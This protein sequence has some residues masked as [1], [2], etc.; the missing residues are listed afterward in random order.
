[1][2]PKVRDKSPWRHHGNLNGLFDVYVIGRKELSE[3][4][5]FVFSDG[6]NRYIENP[7]YPQ[8]I[9]VPRILYVK[10]FEYVNNRSVENYWIHTD[11][12]WDVTPTAG[13]ISTEMNVII[14]DN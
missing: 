9:E 13:K 5:N 10:D 11:I 2:N 8:T 12:V 1:M 7:W 14:W 6:S 3:R 4:F